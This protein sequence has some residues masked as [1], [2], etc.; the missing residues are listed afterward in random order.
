[1]HSQKNTDL[2]AVLIQLFVDRRKK[3]TRAHNKIET[4]KMPNIG[5]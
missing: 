2:A 3:L 1:M 5:F 4:V